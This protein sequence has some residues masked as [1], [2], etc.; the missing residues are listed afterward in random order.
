MEGIL[1]SRRLSYV[2]SDDLEEPLIPAHLLMGWR[3]LSLPDSAAST[4]NDGDDNLQH[5]W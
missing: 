2:S 5:H 4:G 3:I 1:N